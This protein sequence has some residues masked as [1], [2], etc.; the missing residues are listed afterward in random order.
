MF[1][2]EQQ[3]KVK[4]NIDYLRPNSKIIY[5]LYSIDGTKIHDD[6]V[7]LTPQKLDL[8]KNEYGNIIYAL[9]VNKKG[10]ISQKN[11][12][13]ALNKSKEIIEEIATTEKLTK[14][15]YNEA[16]KVID[17]IISDLDS[18]EIEAIN[19]LKNLKS[20]EEYVYQHS[21]NVGIL[22]AVFARLKGFS[23]DEIKFLTLGAYLLDIGLTKIDKYLLKKDSKYTVSEMQKMKQH[24]QF[25]YEI[26]KNISGIDKI[27]LQ[28]VLFHHEKHNYKGY[29][30]LPYDLLPI[31]PKIVSICDIYDALTT[32]R[33]YRHSVS[34]TNALRFLVNSIDIH[35]D[36]DLI[37]DF[38]NHLSPLL[39]NTQSFYK[40][41]D[42]CELNTKE[43]A[44]IMDFSLKDYLKPRVM[45]FCKFQKKRDSISVKFYD[46][47]EYINL[48]DD[49][50]RLLT[51]II[52]NKKHINAIR[53]KLMSKGLILE[54][55][56]KNLD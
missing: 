29:Y 26:I 28:T 53:A 2:T 14:R 41:N 35:F 24:P 16:E 27:V 42:F 50:K 21:V 25:G 3:Q 47:P 36:Y 51:K 17:N 15:A 8:I 33:P 1:T 54:P 30:Q 13:S 34:P 31:S 32:P 39:D 9:K 44:M 45:V 22:A 11:L 19:L 38:I 55:D 20:Y 43:L 37:S 52:D 23:D 5:A 48:E 10:I 6:R 40:K 7:V 56:K 12:D 49:N 4:I 46:N 18:S